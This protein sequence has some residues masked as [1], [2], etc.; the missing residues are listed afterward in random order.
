MRND[1]SCPTGQLIR[2]DEW[3]FPA[4]SS[5]DRSGHAT[6]TG[7]AVAALALRGSDG[8]P[9]GRGDEGRS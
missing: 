2:L 9:Q 7:R 5:T 6:G 8:V 4:A 1:G 3:L